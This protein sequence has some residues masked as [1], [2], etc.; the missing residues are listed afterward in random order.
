MSE[1]IIVNCLSKQIS[2]TQ[3]FGYP[4]GDGFGNQFRIFSQ[5]TVSRVAIK[6]AKN[7]TPTGSIVARLYNS[8]GDFGSPEAYAD[9]LI[10]QS[11]NTLDVS[12]LTENYQNIN[13]TFDDVVLAAGTYFI[14]VFSSAIHIASGYVK[15][16]VT[17]ETGSQFGYITLWD[18][19]GER[20]QPFIWW[21]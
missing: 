3:G 16:A 1:Q 14:V 12:T 9:S 7:G 18:R 17:Y 6:I 4:E 11:T 8:N 20:W 5:A 2:G 10:A 19:E 21:G 15:L 13:F